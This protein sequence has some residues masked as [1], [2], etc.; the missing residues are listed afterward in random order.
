MM[1]AGEAT[2]SIDDTL[3]RLAN[4]L[5]KQYSI[6]K[7]ITSA[8]TYPA[9]LSILTIGV[10]LFL[11]V[12]IVPTFMATFKDM[13]LEMPL[14]TVIVVGISDWLIANWYF[15]IL[16]LV[17]IVVVFNLLYKKNKNFNYSINMTILRMPIFGP[18]MQ[19]ALLLA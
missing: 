10:G 5:E 16:A 9:I 4:T 18:L 6:K 3:D 17:I 1:R 11:M 13:D 7:K 8:L 12:F 14:L 15:M 2:G 19:K